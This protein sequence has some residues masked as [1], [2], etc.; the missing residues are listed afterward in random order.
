MD[1]ML[2]TYTFEIYI[3]KILSMYEKLAILKDTLVRNTGVK[4]RATSAA[5]KV[6]KG[7]NRTRMYVCLA[8]QIR[9]GHAGT[10][11]CTNSK[12]S[13]IYARISHIS[14]VCA[15]MQICAAEKVVHGHP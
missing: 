4:C 13:P 8:V 6:K 2:S 1:D 9:D 11:K 3:P 10:G 12:Y 14:H 7:M 5:K 15:K